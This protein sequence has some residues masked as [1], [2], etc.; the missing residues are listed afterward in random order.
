MLMGRPRKSDKKRT[1]RDAKFYWPER[2]SCMEFMNAIR[3]LLG[4]D[5]I[6]ATTNDYTRTKKCA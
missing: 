2:G 5:E 1:V 6:S 4:L 3:C